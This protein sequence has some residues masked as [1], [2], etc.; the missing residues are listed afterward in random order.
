M[1]NPSGITALP[2]TEATFLVLVHESVA[3]GVLVRVRSRA[4]EARG[5]GAKVRQM[6]DL[7]EF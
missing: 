2:N 3:G 1:W 6:V 5:G 7:H 4:K